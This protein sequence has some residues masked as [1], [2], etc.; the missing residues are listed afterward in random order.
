MEKISILLPSY[1]HELYLKEAIESCL[2][3]TYENIEL[4]IADNS[5]DNSRQIINEFKKD[6]RVSVFYQD[7]LWKLTQKLNFLFKKATGD[8]IKVFHSDDIMAFDCIEKMVNFAKTHDLDF[9]HCDYSLINAKGDIIK[10]SVNKQEFKIDK[11]IISKSSTKLMNDFIRF[12]AR[13]P[14]TLSTLFCKA[15]NIEKIGGWN[16]NFLQEDVIIVYKMH[17]M[18][19]KHGYINEPLWFYRRYEKIKRDPVHT[20]KSEEHFRM[21]MHLMNIALN[22]GL[23]KKETKKIAKK[24]IGTYKA[25]ILQNRHKFVGLIWLFYKRYDPLLIRYYL[26]FKKKDFT[27]NNYIRFV[28]SDIHKRIKLVLKGVRNPQRYY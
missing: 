16:E 1:N 6:K 7:G 14:L 3:Q 21:R 28:L 15:K 22:S 26:I 2:S 27:I 9:V 10:E 11:N 25:E 17:A 12:G 19:F 24:R 5:I 4:L 18:K 23:L 13:G 20:Q 8:Y